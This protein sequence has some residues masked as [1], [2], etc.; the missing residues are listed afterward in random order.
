M[1]EGDEGFRREPEHLSNDEV[2]GKALALAVDVDIDSD[3]D[4]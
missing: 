4:K 2:D 3:R 1:A